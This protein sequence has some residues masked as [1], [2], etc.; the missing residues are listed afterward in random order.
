M[1]IVPDRIAFDN[2]PELPAGA[3]YPE[4]GRRE[5]YRNGFRAGHDVVDELAAELILGN[6]EL[7]DALER[8]QQKGA[9]TYLP[10]TRKALRSARKGA[11]ARGA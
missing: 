7:L 9:D 11:A 6:R 2:L 3:A 10:R 1:P 4:E 8:A 5:A